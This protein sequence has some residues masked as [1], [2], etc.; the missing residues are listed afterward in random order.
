MGRSEADTS[1]VPVAGR[2]AGRVAVVTGAATGIGQAIARRLAAE[3]ALVTVADARDGAETVARIERDG[4]RAQAVECDLGSASSVAGLGRAVRTAHGACDVL[5]NVAATFPPARFLE[6]SWEQWRA[7]M[8]V[9][10]DCL[11][12][13][14]KEFLPAMLE[15]GWGRIVHLTSGVCFA[16][17]FAQ[18]GFS[19]YAGAKAG[20]VGFS[21]ALAAEVGDRGVTVN[22]LAPGVTLTPDLDAARLEPLLEMQALPEI[23]VPG[24]LAAVVAYI[25]S[26]DAARMT[27]HVFQVDGGWLMNT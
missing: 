12:H 17:A 11:F 7:T 16:P 9:N 3:G 26:A 18:A 5:A 24:D 20:V 8:A 4:G 13:V 19:A 2:H 1:Y 10:L 21:R 27:G 25:A 22:V 15:G 14:T 23:T 6:T